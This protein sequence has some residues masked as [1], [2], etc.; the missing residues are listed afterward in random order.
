LLLLLAAESETEE[1]LRED[2]RAAPLLRF[3]DLLLLQGGTA[4]NATRE[5]HGTRPLLLLLL[6]LLPV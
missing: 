2:R 4:R 6:L 5:K 3:L 1:R